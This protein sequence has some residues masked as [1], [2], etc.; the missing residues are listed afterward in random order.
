MLIRLVGTSE[1][2]PFDVMMTVARTYARNEGKKVYVRGR[3][4]ISDHWIY[5]FSWLPRRS[6]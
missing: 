1:Q 3:K 4:D 5:G 2:I 6:N